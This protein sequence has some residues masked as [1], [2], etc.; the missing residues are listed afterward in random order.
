MKQGGFTLIELVVVASIVAVLAMIALPLAELTAQRSRESELRSALRQ[1]REGIDAYKRAVD[2][3]KVAKE[4][5]ESGYPRRLDDL[6]R[7]VEDITLPSKPLIFF[8]RRIPRDPFHA[9]A[10]TPA[11]E[12]W[13]LRAYE[14]PPDQP[15]P[16]NDVY[17]VYSQS[18]RIG[19]N[20][21][22]YRQW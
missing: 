13:G 6:S 16:G 20:G 11:A 3:G 21:I 19:L 22:P 15:R 17:D 18:E 5:T 2:A 12:T 14:S 10:Q 7:G 1:I 4:A 8:L 9:D